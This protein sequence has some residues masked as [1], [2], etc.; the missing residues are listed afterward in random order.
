[1]AR[2]RAVIHGCRGEA[3]RLGSEK[4]GISASVDGWNIGVNV[5]IWVNDA[6]KDQVEVYLSGG[7]N[8]YSTKH[9][10]TFTEGDK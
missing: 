10:G 7:S 4:S 9:L 1:M 5:R 2:F 8:G 3:S 6:G